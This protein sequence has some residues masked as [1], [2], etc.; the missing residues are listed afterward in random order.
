MGFSEE[1]REE[2]LLNNIDPKK[3][4]CFENEQLYQTE[5]T[6]LLAQNRSFEIMTSEDFPVSL[7]K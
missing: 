6:N 5:I 4:L 3:L 1:E 7:Q 2:L